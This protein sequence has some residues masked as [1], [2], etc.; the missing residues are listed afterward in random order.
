MRLTSI[1]VFSLALLFFSCQKKYE[2]YY[3]GS[4]SALKNGTNWSPKING[5]LGE[6]EG[7]FCI[8]LDGFSGEEVTESLG[9]ANIP[10]KTGRTKILRRYYTAIDLTRIVGHYT[11]LLD[12]GD[13]TCDW[14]VVADQDTA[15]NY[16]QVDSFTVATGKVYGKF[17]M[18]LFLQ[19]PKCNATALDTMVFTNGVFETTVY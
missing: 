10:F 11:T 17:A 16:V 7:T 6:N 13:V 12:D 5:A 9:I 4:A 19:L 14:Y 3:T 2:R 1:I 18:K 8:R 15:S